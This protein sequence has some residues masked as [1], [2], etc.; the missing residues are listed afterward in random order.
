MRSLTVCR[1]PKRPA[2]SFRCVASGRPGRI[3]RPR[4]GLHRDG[5]CINTRPDGKGRQRRPAIPQ[6]GRQARIQAGLGV[7][8]G[9]EHLGEALRRAG[10]NGLT[11]LGNRAPF[12]EPPE[13]ELSRAVRTG[14]RLAWALL[15]IYRFKRFNDTC[16][17]RGRGGLRPAGRIPLP[18]CPDP[19]ADR[20][21]YRAKDA[22]C[23][24]VKRAAFRPAPPGPPMADA[25]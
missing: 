13:L 10:T 9:V 1:T 12:G 25:I 22:G 11:G 4:P 19:A 24:C 14:R 7:D 16:G 21:L 8:S 2:A 20:L 18:R 17:Q 23:N 15:D 6:V 3:A 5:Y